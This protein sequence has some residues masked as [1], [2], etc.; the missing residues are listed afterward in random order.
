MWFM[1]SVR[2][3]TGYP[4]KSGKL[5]IRTLVNIMPNMP[6]NHQGDLDPRAARIRRILALK[7]DAIAVDAQNTGG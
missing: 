5:N 1:A 2:S 3:F 4:R 6:E 7:M